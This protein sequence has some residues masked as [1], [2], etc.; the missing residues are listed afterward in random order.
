MKSLIAPE[1]IRILNDATPKGR[2]YVLY[3]MQSS[4]R[5]ED[6]PALA[7]AIGR[8]NAARLPLVVYFGLATG[9]PEAN[10]RHIRFMLEGISD[11]ARSLETPGIRFVLRVEE[12]DLGILALAHDA[13][14]LVVDRGYL[15]PERTWYRSVAGR[16]PCP[17]V[18]VEGNSIVPVQAA[19]EKEEYSAATIRPKITRLLD[20]FLVP[21]GEIDHVRSMNAPE[22]P[23]L[24]G[25]KPDKILDGMTIDRSVPASTEFTGGSTEAERRFA[26]FLASGL[27]R[28]ADDRNDPGT[29]TASGMS[30][31]LH[32]GQVSPVTLALRVQDA[33]GPG[34]AAFLEELIVRRELAVNFVF[35]ND[36]HDSFDALPAWA[37]RTLWSHAED[38][39]EYVYTRDEL[40]RAATH[41]P[42]WNAAQ[43]EMT[44][45]G[46]MQGYMRMYWGK[47]ILEWSTTPQEAYATAL[48][49][50][51]RYEIDGRDPNSFAGV[52]WCFGKHDR[53]WQ[54][55]PV[56]GMVRYMNAA[57]L[58]RKFTMNRYVARINGIAGTAPVLS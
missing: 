27:E 31:Y 3:W 25:E 15:R 38:R 46:T 29:G 54:E 55:R 21:T 24:A 41:D 35:Y 50:N 37:K 44:V 53:P 47:K 14:L 39:R 9:Y 11:V 56:F 34:S 10:I 1:R 33:G 52:A 5:I 8:A 30:P 12:P 18:Q 13:A 49:L 6:N 26:R 32:F 7:Y 23:T 22:F 51:N 40:E 43:K 57:G 16:C 36:R 48:Y 4:H 2:D 20:R 58:E 28:F 45:T 17:F 19:S 42:Y